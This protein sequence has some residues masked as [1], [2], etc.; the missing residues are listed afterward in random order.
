MSKP[1]P[2]DISEYY[3]E[4]VRAWGEHTLPP[5]EDIRVTLEPAMTRT[6]GRAFPRVFRRPNGK[7]VRRDYYAITLSLPWFKALHDLSGGGD[8]VLVQIRHT[9]LHELAHIA[10]FHTYPNARVPGHGEEWKKLCRA[11]GIRDRATAWNS[12]HEPVTSGSEIC[13][14][15]VRDQKDS[16]LRSR[17]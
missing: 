14:S 2:V 6:I 8:E 16:A 12:D 13:W 3:E 10:I 4:A 17:R 11:V 5:L 7:I 15:A 1:R 9:V